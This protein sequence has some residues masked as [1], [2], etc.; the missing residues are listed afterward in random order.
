M[1]EHRTNEARD[2]VFSTRIRFARNCK[3]YPFAA[4]LDR[5][6]AAEIIEKV[7]RAAGDDYIVTDMQSLSA[8]E[9]AR[10]VE[11]HRVS[12]EFLSVT[13]PHI[14]L[15][16]GNSPFKSSS[17]TRRRKPILALIKKMRPSRKNILPVVSVIISLGT[18]KLL[19][20]CG[21]TAVQKAISKG[22]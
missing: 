7:T 19:V 11:R 3:E 20:P 18:T 9:A 1:S 4:K 14:L 12:R 5:T 8:A 21:S 22:N 6:S 10:L 2:V 13:V 16:H 15:E 17:T